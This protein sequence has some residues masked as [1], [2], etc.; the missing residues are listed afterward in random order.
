MKFR[1]P[2]FKHVCGISIALPVAHN[3]TPT[4][5]MSPHEIAY[6][7]GADHARRGR[8]AD[9][10]PYDETNHPGLHAEWVRGH[11]EGST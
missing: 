5:T 9:E 4:P 7:K 1:Q 2:N 10:N 3:F 11:T 8:G 6:A